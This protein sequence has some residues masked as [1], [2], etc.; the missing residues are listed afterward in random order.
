MSILTQS[1]R[2][3]KI[4]HKWNV[5]LGIVEGIVAYNCRLRNFPIPVLSLPFWEGAG[6][7]A[8]DVSGKMNHGSLVNHTK[9]VAGMSGG[10][11][12]QLDGADDY[13]STVHT[14]SVDITG[15]VITLEAWVNL[16][17]R[18]NPTYNTIIGKQHWGVYQY[19]MV[20]AGA[21][22]GP[23][24]GKVFFYIYDGTTQ[25]AAYG[26][27]VIPFNV[28]THLI[29]TADGTNVKFYY[30]G[31]LDATRA[32]GGIVMATNSQQLCIGRHGD[33]KYYFDGK[34]DAARIYNRDLSAA[35]AMELCINPYGMFI[36]TIPPP[37]ETPTCS[38]VI[39]I[40]QKY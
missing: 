31:N 40:N 6:N 7:R 36:D 22:W 39:Q 10:T 3:P 23:D 9:W 16:R 11:A 30:N 37:C 14:A 26:N 29:V 33:N 8:F 13:I 38:F 2:R 5:P 12:L 4:K 15:S 25:L 20:I 24:A 32:Q 18:T 27:T 34:I 28:W 35:Q 21:N 1:L 19:G 17:A